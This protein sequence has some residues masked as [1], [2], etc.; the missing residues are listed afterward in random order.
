MS[1]PGRILFAKGFGVIAGAWLAQAALAGEFRAGTLTI[2]QP[3][4]RATPPGAT[5][6]AAYFEIQNTGAVPDTLLRVECAVA[7]HPT[8]HSMSMEGGMMHMR[9]LASVSVPAHG[10]LRFDPNGMHIMLEDLGRPLKEGEHFSLT[11]VFEHAGRV[12][13]EVPVRGMGAISGVEDG[14]T[15]ART[16]Q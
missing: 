16:S 3:W 7:R 12:T 4:S 9:P 1:Y 13:V 11:F 10:R 5:V 14:G 8:M 15:H 2:V 6:G